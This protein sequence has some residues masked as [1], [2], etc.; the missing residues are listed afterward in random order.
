MPLSTARSRLRSSLSP[1]TRRPSAARFSG[2]PR[3]SR[4]RA[5]IVSEASTRSSGVLGPK[6]RTMASYP[7]VPGSTTLRASTSASTMGSE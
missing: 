6:C 4:P 1:K 5:G 2:R 3:P 7:P